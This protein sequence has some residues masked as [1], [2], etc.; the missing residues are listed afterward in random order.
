MR[1]LPVWRFLELSN[2]C[3]GRGRPLQEALAPR[4][5]A[6]ICT[7][8]H[9]RFQMSSSLECFR[10]RQKQLIVCHRS[11]CPFASRRRSCAPFDVCN[12]SVCLHSGDLYSAALPLGGWPAQ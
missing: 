8:S 1:D 2:L 3:V 12:D 9:Y 10:S 11:R 6:A 5:A 4:T 7:K